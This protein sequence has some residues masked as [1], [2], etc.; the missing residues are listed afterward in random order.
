M[1]AAIQE[2]FILL[3]T[4]DPD[5]WRII[6]VSL[7]VSLSALLIATPPAVLNSCQPTSSLSVLA[8]GADVTAYVP[9]GSWSE[10]NTGVKRVK[11]EGP[12][13]IPGITLATAKP[14]NSCASNWVTGQTVC[15]SNANDVY[16]I[17]GSTLTATLLSGGTGTTDFSGG[18]C[19][20]CG[21]AIDAGS[22]QAVIALSL[23]GSAGF[24][25]LD[26]A[27]NSFTAPVPAGG[28]V[29]EDISID[30]VRHLLLSPTEQ[31]NYQIMQIQPAKALFDNQVGPPMSLEFDSAAEDCTTG[32][33]LSSIEFTNQLFLSDLTQAVFTPGAPRGTW[34]T[35]VAA[36]LTQTFPQFSGL[37]AGT[38]G[39][40]VAQ[41]PH[42][43]IVAGEFGGSAFGVVQLPS[44]SGGS[45]AAV[46]WVACNIPNDPSGA[47]WSMGRDPHTVTAYVSPTTGKGIGVVANLSRTYLA[48]VDMALLITSQTAHT[49]PAVLPAGAIT[50]VAIP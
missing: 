48:L 13:A 11:L 23:A 30:P 49:C 27:T 18:Q 10:L 7:K 34:S 47:V 25:F 37:A 39:I 6:W 8:Q 33:A 15:T 16:V 43:A 50:F 32:I 41:G 5:L 19:T 31:T 26:L 46:D 44:A 40:A 22:N 9:L 28:H 2:A 12:S 42:L 3:F 24:Q 1:S 29:S 45:P 35:P 17:S 21:V 20:N 38:S 36:S 4:G 14:V